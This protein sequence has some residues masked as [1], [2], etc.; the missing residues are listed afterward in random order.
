ME[1]TSEIAR[2][3]FSSHECDYKINPEMTKLWIVITIRIKLDSYYKW[4]NNLINTHT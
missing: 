1:N 3:S 4:Q 2:F